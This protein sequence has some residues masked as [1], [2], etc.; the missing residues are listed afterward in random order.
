MSGNS[1]IVPGDMPAMTPKQA[2]AAVNPGDL[3]ECAANPKAACTTSAT[4]FMVKGYDDKHRCHRC[5]LLHVEL[6]M[7]EAGSSAP[8]IEPKFV[9]PKQD[10]AAQV[11][12]MARIESLNQKLA[13]GIVD[14]KGRGHGQTK[15]STGIPVADNTRQLQPGE[16]VDMRDAQIKDEHQTREHGI[17]V[18]DR[19][20]RILAKYQ[21]RIDGNKLVR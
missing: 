20:A 12:R 4:D 7:Q 9:A 17:S 11:A 3:S 8:N 5:N 21:K 15:G 10:K 16:A 18:E 14:I 6:V 2:A 19:R 13:K 1:I